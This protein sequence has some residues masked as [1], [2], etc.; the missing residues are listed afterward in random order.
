LEKSE[1]EKYIK[2]RNE[3][4]RAKSEQL[5]HKQYL[6]K[7]ALKQKLDLEFEI[8]RK[9]KEDEMS[10]IILKF[11]NK[12]LDL[13]LQQKQERLLSENSNMQRASNIYIF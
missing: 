10:K 9:S 11:K 2:E 3:K 5:G 4:I 8:A 12:K 7:S 6:E 1:T 13:E